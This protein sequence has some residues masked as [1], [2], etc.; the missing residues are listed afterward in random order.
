[1]RCKICNVLYQLSVHTPSYTHAQTAD[2]KANDILQS[3]QIQ[4]T[5]W[6]SKKETLICLKFTII[7]HLFIV[8]L[9]N[10]PQSLT[11]R[12]FISAYRYNFIFL[13]SLSLSVKIQ[14]HSH[15][16]TFQM[17]LWPFMISSLSLM[18][19]YGEIKVS[20]SEAVS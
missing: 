11:L 13:H 14:G 2:N 12:F 4:K 6:V 18:D 16:L 19:A 1:M 5:Y 9:Q 15:N 20:C 10:F 17:T 3:T 8:H 7:T